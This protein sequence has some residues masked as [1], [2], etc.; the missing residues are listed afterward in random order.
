MPSRLTTVFVS[1]LLATAVVM[2]WLWLV[3]QAARVG[4]HCPADCQCDTAGYYVQCKAVPGNPIPFIRLTNI[5]VLQLYGIEL[6]LLEKDSF[7]SMTDLL[8]L[9]VRWCGL[10]T[11]EL[12]AFHG[13]T[14]LTELTVRN[15]K[16]NSLLKGTFEDVKSLEY[17]DLGYNKIKQLNSAMFSGL[18]A[19]NGLINLRQLIV[20]CNKISEIMP[21]TFENMSCLEYIDLRENKIKH[22]NG[23]VFSG[24]G[25]F[26]GLTKLTRLSMWGNK[27]SEIL[28]GTFEG[29]SSLEYLDLRYNRIEQLDSVVFSGLGAFKGLTKL[30]ELLMQG[31][32]I[33]ELLTGTFEGTSSLQNLDLSYNNITQLDS[34]VFSGL[35]D[36]KYVDLSANKLQYLHPHTF[37]KLP[38][39]KRLRLKNNIALQIPTDRNFISSH[40]LSKLDIA[41]CNISS[42]TAETFA[43]VSALNSLDL[44]YNNMGTVNINILRALPELSK[45]YLYG[46]PLQ[47]DCELQEVWRWCEDRH[48]DT[49]SEHEAPECDTPMEL[50]AMWWGVLENGQCFEGNI[51]YFG[52]YKNTSYRYTGSG[53]YD[54]DY[55]NRYDVNILNQYQVPVYAVPFI[56]STTGNIILLIIIICNKDMRTVPN[57]YILNLAISDIICVT[58]VF[59]EACRN[60]LFYMWFYDDFTC[61]FLSFCRRMSVGLSAYSVALYSF[62]R[63]RVTVSPFQVRVSS[64]TNWRAMV[65]EIYGVWTVAALFAVPSTLTNY[66]CQESL[67][68]RFITNYQRVVIFELLVSCVLPV[69]VIAFSYIK[70]ARHLVESSRV[71]TERT[72]NRQRKTRRNAAKIVLGLTVVFVI[73]YVPY[74][75]FWTYY[76]S[77]K[78][79]ILL[80]YS[81][82]DLGYSN[83]EIQYTYLISTCFLLINS[84]LNPVAMFSTSSQFRQHLKSYLTCFC[85]TSSPS[86]DF[87]LE[88]RN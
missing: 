87:E 54:Y 53:D 21:G 16:L 49:G 68:V 34:D 15:N 41:N 28:K 7:V 69:C 77:S 80:S 13:L 88:I 29:M 61:R 45:L 55:E 62:Q 30:T 4:K 24:L 71:M 43:N 75:A 14:K 66:L 31:N 56:F 11:I 59:S 79:D 27:I 57:M 74:H 18:G 19:V 67:P 40:S 3:I 37:L 6:K 44:S 50:K 85:K 10:R 82:D 60:R 83:F 58:V 23:A 22:L 5:Q 48:I 2:Y 86:T 8:L 78:E 26:K 81:T 36:L 73:S 39:M 42:L 70:T 9:D 20:A 84:C 32:R 46:N 76:I 52:D 38:N 51:E 64:Q 35:V 1:L 65:A 63:Y 25:A 33:S 12:G 47:C 72:E 17:L